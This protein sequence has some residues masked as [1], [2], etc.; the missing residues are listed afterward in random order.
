MRNS[1]RLG[2]VFGIAI[3]LDY[4]WFI[5]FALVTWSLAAQYF[6][7]YYPG[8][9]WGTY[10][11]VG[12]IASLLF[13]ASVLAHELSHSLV[14]RSTGISVHSITLFIFGGVAQITAEPKR[15]RDELLITLAGPA[16]SLVIAALFG[17]LWF[18]TKDTNQ[19]VS[20]LASWLGGI[21]AI[22]A[23]FNLI[24]GFPLDGGRVLRSIVWRITGNL[25]RAT[26]IASTIGRVVAFLFIFAGILL[27]FR[28]YWLNGLWIAFI[29]WFLENAAVGSYRQVALREMLQGITASEV[30]MRDCPKVPPSL[31]LEQLVHEYILYAGRR[32]FPVVLAE[33][34][35]GIITL[36]HV[37]E[38]P[39]E[40]WATTTVGQVMTP[41]AQIKKVKPNEELS[42][43]LEIM[44]SEDVNQLPVVEEGKLV[45]MVAR[46]NVLAFIKARSELGI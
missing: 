14:A 18:L 4:S 33:Q 26:W 2:K 37:K 46:D 10:W 15:P 9:P 32:C 12:L 30:M 31:T 42:R 8:W 36:H 43:V 6:P 17:A 1:L 44:T 21:N 29:G 13:F 20:A 22:L 39:K 34:V 19:E 38:I 27:A 35:Q 11:L 28:G 45:G 5:V 40:R 23:V 41:F 16:T 7:Q 3:G 24:P 25:K